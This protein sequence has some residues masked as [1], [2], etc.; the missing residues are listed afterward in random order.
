MAQ[1]PDTSSIPRPVQVSTRRQMT[2]A[3]AKK[4]AYAAPLVVATMKLTERAVG[5]VSG[6]R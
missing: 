5:A 2:K 6:V 4:L 3:A 1:R